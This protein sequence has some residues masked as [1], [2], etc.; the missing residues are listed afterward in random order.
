MNFFMDVTGVITNSIP[1]NVNQGGDDAYSINLYTPFTPGAV[2]T[3]SFRLPNGEIKS[4]YALT[5]KG[6]ATD[7]KVN[8]AD[9]YLWTLTLPGDITRYYGTVTMQFFVTFSNRTLASTSTSFIVGKGVPQVIEDSSPLDTILENIAALQSDLD[10]GYFAARAIRPWNELYTYGAGEIVW[11]PDDS[12][13]LLIESIKNNNKDAPY[14]DGK[15]NTASWKL[16]LDRFVTPLS[17]ALP[18]MD[19]VATAGTSTE[20]SRS[21]H[22]H[23]TDISRASKQELAEETAARQSADATLQNNI[24]AEVEARIAADNLKQDKTDNSLSTTAKTIVG[25]INE[26]KTSIDG[27]RQDVINN[28]HFKG[29]AETAEDVQKITGDVNDFVYCIA[30]GTIWTYGATGW[31]DSKKPYPS[32]A[33]PLA[34]TTPIMDGTAAVGTS[35]SAARADHVHPQDTVLANRI[36]ALEGNVEDIVDGTTPVA[37]AIG[38]GEGNNIINTYATKAVATQTTDGLM[39]AE[40]K[41]ALDTLA[42]TVDFETVVRYTEQSGVTA[43]QQTQA[44]ENIGLPAQSAISRYN[45]GAFDTYV[46]NGDGT[47]TI[48]RQ[49]YYLKID[50][51]VDTEKFHIEENRI[52]I[53]MSDKTQCV[54]TKDNPNDTVGDIRTNQG[55]C[56]T[57]GQTLANIE[58]GVSYYNVSPVFN[59]QI[60]QDFMGQTL[61]TLEAAQEYF[62][63][64]P[65]YIQLK[66]AT[67][68]TENVISARPINTLDQQAMWDVREEWEKGLNVADIYFGGTTQYFS[69]YLIG[70]PALTPGETYTISLKT[71]NTGASFYFSEDITSTPYMQR[72]INANGD[73]FT[74][75]FTVKDTYVFNNTNGNQLIKNAV[76][77]SA[78]N[79]AGDSLYDIMIVKGGVGYPYQPY[80]GGIIREDSTRLLRRNHIDNNDIIGDAWHRIGSLP[81][82]TMDNTG[83]ETYTGIFMINSIYNKQGASGELSTI[84]GSGMVEL[85]VRKEGSTSAISAS[86]SVLSGNISTGDVC[87]V[88]GSSGV[89]LYKCVHEQYK[90]A[91]ITIL[92]ESTEHKTDENLFVFNTDVN[93]WS[94]S[95]PSGAIYAVNRNTSSLEAN[96]G[97]INGNVNAT[98]TVSEQ[99]QRVY[100]PNNPQPYAPTSAPTGSA[101]NLYAWSANGGGPP[102]W[103]QPVVKSVNGSNAG[104]QAIYAPYGVGADNAVLGWSNN[105][106]AWMQLDS[107]QTLSVRRMHASSTNPT[108]DSMWD[109]P[110]QYDSFN[111][112]TRCFSTGSFNIYA[113]LFDSSLSE[114]HWIRIDLGGRT[115]YSIMAV[116]YRKNPSGGAPEMCVYWDNSAA[117]GYAYICCDEGSI[118]DGEGIS[119]VIFASRT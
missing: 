20:A 68:Y 24:N 93:D 32:D 82:S 90:S 109:T 108:G 34:T 45:L 30:T 86:L 83:Y 116:P 87:Y 119:F 69:A 118:D 6:V 59:I 72:A 110:G 103:Q 57:P 98:G 99:G 66:L 13:N 115:I 91:Q 71:K 5:Y 67:P 37:R 44:Q 12:G 40:D 47:A 77:N 3:A 73:P 11:Y 95:A 1:V 107:G 16:A 35:S 22:V 96:G 94:T 63:A 88:I 106:P 33:T 50:N 46:D 26:N 17:D 62:G 81:F 36:T 97:T 9:V 7:V 49:T 55:I 70:N 74:L 27:L 58:N 114:D 23:P 117:K 25:A 101:N 84:D 112:S 19:G 102:S 8:G 39:S 41:V 28:D 92:G 113:G 29:F 111:V 4:L 75:T 21:D 105:E 89:D 42:G 10:N 56:V 31:T 2:V 60:S 15:L 43:E 61:N 54:A 80:H 48:T 65:L 18:K 79:A 38:D 53:D 100:S 52:Y 51:T 78:T 104:G 76:D 85:D 64:H 14:V